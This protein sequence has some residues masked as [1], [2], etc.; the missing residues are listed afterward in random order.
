[1]WRG[2]GGFIKKNKMLANLTPVIESEICGVVNGE[3]EREES[4][5]LTS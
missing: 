3:E 5:E 2:R 1:M 4:F